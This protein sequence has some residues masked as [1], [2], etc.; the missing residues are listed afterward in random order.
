M[1]PPGGVIWESALT[2]GYAASALRT[3]LGSTAEKLVHHSGA[4]VLVGR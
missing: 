2:L 4:S 3:F 1:L